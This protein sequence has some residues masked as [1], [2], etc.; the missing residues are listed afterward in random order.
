MKEYTVKF[1]EQEDYDKV[2]DEMTMESIRNT[3]ERIKRGWIPDYN[4]KGTEDDI[5]NYECHIAMRKA[6]DFI[7]EIESLTNEYNAY[8]IDTDYWRGIKYALDCIQNT[9]D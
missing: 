4:F 8:H 7:K 9:N 5:E 3:L 2:R 1:Y 6:I